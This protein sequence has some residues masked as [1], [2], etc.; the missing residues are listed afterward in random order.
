[1]DKQLQTIVDNMRADVVRIVAL[2]DE[3]KDV[4][5]I[6]QALMENAMQQAMRQALGMVFGAVPQTATAADLDSAAGKPFTLAF[7]P[8]FYAHNS[9][10]KPLALL[11]EDD[12]GVIYKDGSQFR[13]LARNVE[14]SKCTHWKLMKHIYSMTMLAHT[15]GPSMPVAPGSRVDVETTLGT[16]RRDLIADHVDWEYVARYRVLS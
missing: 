2:R 3:G 16:M 1:M 4:E 6:V 14:W 10:T 11:D 7:H 13:L 8:G 9:V 12:V 5:Q 15:S